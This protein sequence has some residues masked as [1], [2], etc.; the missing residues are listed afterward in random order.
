MY[1]RL[2]INI[3]KLKHNVEVISDI[4]KKHNITLA[5]VTKSYCALPE[6]VKKIISADVDYIADS[7]IDNLKKLKDINIPKILIRIPMISEARDAIS[8]C[9]ISFNSELKTIYK[10]NEEARLQNKVHNIALMVDL[11]DLREGYF[12]EV[13]LYEVVEKIL[14]LKNI[15]LIGVA[16]NLTCYGTIIPST[17]NLERLSNIAN[18]IE[19]KYNIN[20]NFISGGNSSSVYLLEKNEMPSKI[21]NLRIGESIVLGRE[22]AYGDIIENTYI[23]AFKL[24]CEIVEIKEKPSIPIGERGMDAFGNIQ[25]YEDKGIRKRA[26]L[27]I[28]K[29]DIN[30]ESV[31]PL[32]EK[33]SIFGAS[34]DHMIID[35]SD[36]NNDYDIGDKIE[37]ILGYGGLMSA[38]TS[39]YIYKVIV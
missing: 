23:D 6:V 9:D 35:I 21:N 19:N 4:C 17:E 3:D 37:F 32:D 10:L 1:P 2:E 29:Q 39:E 27:A 7:R 38:S 26:I 16:T 28:G 30:I 25:T 22:T 13:E 24:I 36:S 15:K 8:Y 31:I 5:M 33:I 20:L 11:G 34:S 18:N 14:T 12:K